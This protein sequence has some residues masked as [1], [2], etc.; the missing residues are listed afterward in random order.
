MIA[1]QIVDRLRCP[2]CG[3]TV[4][5]GRRRP[6]RAVP[7]GP[8]VARSGTATS[9]ARRGRCPRGPPSA[10]FASF[11]FEW[12]TF[13]DVRDEDEGF[14]E[15]YFRDLDLAAL[16]GKVG[17]D[18]GCGKGRYTR[19]L[20]EHLGA[21]GRPGRLVGG[22][23]GRPQPGRLPVGPGGPV[24]PPPR[25]VRPG[26]LRLHRQPRRPPPPGR[27]PARGSSGWSSYLA[28]GGQILLYLYS[29]PADA[30]LRS[31]ALAAGR[32]PAQGHRAPAPPR[33]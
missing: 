3:E 5:P 19:F 31:A 11:G 14:A 6:G 28:P 32:R 15:V 25:P 4:K 21:D 23:G 10:T 24:G 2:Q 22:R 7:V 18:A 13:D 12:N 20:A 29:R 16:T 30:G 9:T 1:D 17:L 33:S 8:P 26:E 27:P